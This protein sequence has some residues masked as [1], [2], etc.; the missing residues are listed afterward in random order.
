IGIL[1]TMLTTILFVFP[2]QIP[3]TA[4]NMNY[5][6]VALGIMFLIAG[7]TWIFDGRKHYEGPR[8]D[9][10]ALQD[11]QIPVPGVQSGSPCG[12]SEREDRREGEGVCVDVTGGGKR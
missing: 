7:A 3:V 8:L 4:N 2:P 10:R 11:G 5:C 6:I 9:V 12:D 1:W